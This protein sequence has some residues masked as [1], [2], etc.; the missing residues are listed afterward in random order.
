M[1]KKIKNLSSFVTLKNLVFFKIAAQPF[2][3]GD[4]L[5]IFLKFL[6]F[7][8]SF[9]F[10]YF[11]YKKQVVCSQYFGNIHGPSKLVSAITSSVLLLLGLL[12]VLETLLKN[13]RQ[14]TQESFRFE[15][16]NTFKKWIL[17]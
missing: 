6:G 13:L 8:G 16:C 1:K 10:N 11:S 5:N 4:F 15:A 17:P 14:E 12:I 2:E 7:W 9:C 3:V